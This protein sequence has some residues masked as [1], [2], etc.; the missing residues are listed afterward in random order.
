[1]LVYIHLLLLSTL[2]TIFYS[3]LV[4]SLCNIYDLTPTALNTKWEAFALSNQMDA[5]KLTISYVRIL[6]TQLKRDFERNLKARRTTKGRV[7]TK[8]AAGGGGLSSGINFSDF[9]LD[10]GDDNQEDSV[11]N[12]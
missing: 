10:N 9:G 1:M 7:I 12:L 2:L 11:E 4:E 8:R 3:P 5:S 6:A